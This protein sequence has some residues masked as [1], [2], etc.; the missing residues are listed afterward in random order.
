M[1]GGG[2]GRLCG[3]N[4]FV[5]SLESFAGKIDLPKALKQAQALVEAGFVSFDGADIYGPSEL[6]MGELRRLWIEQY[7]QS[8]QPKPSAADSKLATA[9]VQTSP[10]TAL[11]L[12][13][14][15]GVLFRFSALFGF[16]LSRFRN[17]ACMAQLFLVIWPRNTC[18]VR[19]I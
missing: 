19:V 18:R 6:L 9:G 16:T 13:A 8:R 10:S 4:G 15:A 5:E 17:V 7:I 1:E 14:E 11:R 3:W 2:G 12:E